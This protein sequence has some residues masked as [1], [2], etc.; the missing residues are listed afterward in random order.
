MWTLLQRKQISVEMFVTN[1][2]RS[3]RTG[4]K[5]KH[6]RM[7]LSVERLV[8]WRWWPMLAPLY[9]GTLH[10]TWDARGIYNTHCKSTALPR[11]ADMS[12]T[13]A[14]GV[15]FNTAIDFGFLKN[16]FAT[17]LNDAAYAAFNTKG[18]NVS[19]RA[20]SRPHESWTWKSSRKLIML[21]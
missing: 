15:I 19:P 11:R 9:A 7:H 6:E 21:S 2:C 5:Q 20:T 13:R 8:R 14:G 12:I 16:C 1:H 18:E 17:L 4:G 3:G 10:S